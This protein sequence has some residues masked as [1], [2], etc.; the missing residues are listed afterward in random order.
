M[1]VLSNIV[2][3][4]DYESETKCHHEWET[5]GAW[6]VIIGLSRCKKCGKRSRMSDFPR[7]K[8]TDEKRQ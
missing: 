8:S 1:E 2:Q 6:G 3:L 4:E 5:S 7:H